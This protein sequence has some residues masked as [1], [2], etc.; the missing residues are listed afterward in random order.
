M[1]AAARAAL[2]CPIVAIGGITPDNGRPLIQAGADMLA[3]IRGVFA[4]PDVT[5]AAQ[6]F[7]PLFD[8]SPETR[9]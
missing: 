4:A 2:N 6:A 7:A 8:F 5:A 3:V 9:P 1:L